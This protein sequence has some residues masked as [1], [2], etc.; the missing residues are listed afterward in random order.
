MPG[1]G[2]SPLA[3]LADTES[4]ARA[5]LRL[6]MLAWCSAFTLGACALTSLLITVEGHISSIRIYVRGGAIT[7]T[8]SPARLWSH[9][10]LDDVHFEASRDN[11]NLVWKPRLSRG[12]A[13]W[14]HYL[15]ESWYYSA[16]IPLW[17]PTIALS[18]LGMWFWRG[19]GAPSSDFCPGCDYD[20][21][22]LADHCCPECGLQARIA[23]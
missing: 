20:L 4:M 1:V 10:R 2:S 12:Y 13:G 7:A 9:P 19:N 5:R 14:P 17:I 23:A 6:A 15:S 21:C 22:G 11:A 16:D 8:G 18:A 3:F